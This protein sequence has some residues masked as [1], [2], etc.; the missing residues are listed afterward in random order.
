MDDIEGEKQRDLRGTLFNG[1]LLQRV[2]LLR[3]VE[4]QYRAG[5]SLPDDLCRLRTREERRTSNLGELADLLLKAHSPQEGFNTPGDL[6]FR[7][8]GLRFSLCFR[9]HDL[10]HNTSS[11]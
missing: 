7:W 11:M 3:V 10:R 6:S 9:S 2:E 1:D 5:S 8:Y 4:P